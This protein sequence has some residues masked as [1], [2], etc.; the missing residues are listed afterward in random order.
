[1]VKQIHLKDI[2]DVQRL[3]DMACEQPYK[4]S[5]SCGHRSLDARSMLA[6]FALIGRK[7][8]FLVAPDHLNA[9]EFMKVIERLAF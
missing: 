9:D 1:M 6:L 5:V 7:D 8:V 2:E 4:L 3:N